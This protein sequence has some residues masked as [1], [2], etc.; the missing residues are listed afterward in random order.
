MGFVLSGLNDAGR[1]EVKVALLSVAT[2]GIAL[3]LFVWRWA[4]QLRGKNAFNRCFACVD[5]PT[6]SSRAHTTEAGHGET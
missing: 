1:P 5:K 2:V 3:A 6:A 4:H